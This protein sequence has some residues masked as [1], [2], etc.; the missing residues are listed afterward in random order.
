MAGRVGQSRLGGSS[1]FE[2]REV[3][4]SNPV[5][6]A[7]RRRCDSAGGRRRPWSSRPPQ[8]QRLPPAPDVEYEPW[9]VPRAEVS[10]V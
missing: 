6:W 3:E 8:T 5:V 9:A 2:E 1:G 7:V 10:S 4:T